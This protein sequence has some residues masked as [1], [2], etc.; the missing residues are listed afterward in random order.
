MTFCTVKGMQ[1]PHRKASRSLNPSFE[2]IH[3]DGARYLDHKI[4]YICL[5]CS[6][7]EQFRQ[8]Q[9][10]IMLKGIFCIAALPTPLI[11]CEAPFKKRKHSTT[12]RYRAKITRAGI[13]DTKNLTPN[14]DNSRLCSNGGWTP[15]QSA[16]AW[17]TI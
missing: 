11:P 5:I 16:R 6:N 12:S 1:Q 9:P 13:L 7:A 15:G 17:T 10:S 3:P 2:T 8:L 14:D 4:F